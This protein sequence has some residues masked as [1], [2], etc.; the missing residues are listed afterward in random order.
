[1]G[2]IIYYSL[3]NGINGYY[4]ERVEE[5]K[6]GEY[7]KAC[8]ELAQEQTDAYK[9]PAK[10]VV[11]DNAKFIKKLINASSSK[12]H[13]TPFVVSMKIMKVND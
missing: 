3:S 7:S 5:G 13:G 1:M 8:V 6:L 4:K 2:F 9:F 12:K 10:S 11:K